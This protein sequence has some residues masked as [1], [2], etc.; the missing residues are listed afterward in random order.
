MGKPPPTL[1]AAIN[2]WLTPLARYA[3]PEEQG[4]GTLILAPATRRA[5]KGLVRQLQDG[6]LLN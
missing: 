2:K 3:G 6:R 5:F 1:T 4:A